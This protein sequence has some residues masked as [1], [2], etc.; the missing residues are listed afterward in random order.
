M[1][2]E[3]CGHVTVYTQ[4]IPEDD[5]FGDIYIWTLA[6]FDEELLPNIE[7]S[8]YGWWNSVEFPYSCCDGVKVVKKVKSF[9]E[10]MEW[11]LEQV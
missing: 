2:C 3:C 11:L 10:A 7:A 9:N 5:C 1:K 6:P 8:D 4:F